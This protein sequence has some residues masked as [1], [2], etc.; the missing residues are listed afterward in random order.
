MRKAPLLKLNLID[1]KIGNEFQTERVKSYSAP[2][3][4]ADRGNI[5]R[6]GAFEDEQV[7]ILRDCHSVGAN[8]KLG[9]ILV[10]AASLFH[11]NTASAAEITVL[12][13]GATKEV[14]VELVP[15]FEKSSGHEASSLRHADKHDDREP[16]SRNRLSAGQ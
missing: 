9:F 6:V 1:S 5:I 7:T 13:S 15:Q 8:M 11:F 16:R 2:I 12:A 14:I 3:N 10:A 4:L